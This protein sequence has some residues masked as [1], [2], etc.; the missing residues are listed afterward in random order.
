MRF[1]L[2]QHADVVTC[3]RIARVLQP[4]LDGE[5]GE[6]S[7]VRIARITRHLDACRRCGLEV[8]IYTEIK[9]TLADHGR[10]VDEV[11]LARLRS[12]AEH[13]AATDGQCETPP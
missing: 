8:R 3:R 5:L 11:T 13:L 7:A 9:N 10:I 6:V 1:W 12:F 4:Y 2:R